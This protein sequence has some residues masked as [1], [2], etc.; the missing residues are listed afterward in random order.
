M[1]GFDKSS[2]RKSS[3]KGSVNARGLGGFWDVERWADGFGS[4]RSKDSINHMDNA[5]AGH[6]ISRGNLC[7]V[8]GDNTIGNAEG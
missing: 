6:H 4:W 8:D 3:N 5:V 7:I 2:M 1:E